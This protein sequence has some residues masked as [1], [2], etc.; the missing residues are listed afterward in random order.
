MVPL[1]LLTAV[2]AQIYRYRRISTPREQEQTK[3]VVFGFVLAILIIALNLPIG[4][5]LPAS[6]TDNQV[7]S[8]LNPVFPVALTDGAGLYRDR[9]FALAALGHRHPHQQG[10][11]LWLAHRAAG[12]AL[13]RSHHRLAAPDRRYCQTGR[14]Q[15]SHLGGLDAGYR[16]PL[17]A[18][19]YVVAIPIDRAFYRRKYDAEK[20]LSAFGRSLGQEVDLEQIRRQLVA[21]AS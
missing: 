15:S 4:F 16:R 11:G 18:A 19:A 20:T 14:L 2:V 10:A 3:W 21:V 5:L 12:R 9:H 7:L 17:P 13:R 8:N 6:V 1:Y